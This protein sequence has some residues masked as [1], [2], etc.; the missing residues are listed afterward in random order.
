MISSR[1]YDL[2]WLRVIAFL[3][4]I[5]FHS[6][7]FF[8]PGGIPMI[9]NA[10]TSTGLEVFVHISSQF[11]LGLL[12][13]I[14]GVGV[15]FARRR[16][17][18]WEFVC[19]RSRRLLIPLLV[20]I[21]FIVP[22]MIYVEKLFLGEYVGSFVSFYP[23]FFTQGVYPNGNLS[24]HHFWFIAYLFIYCLMAVWIFDWMENRGK[25]AVDRWVKR[26]GG[27]GIYK[28]IALLLAIEIPL[29]ALFP[30]FRDLIHDWASFSHWFLLFIA[31][32][33]V[34]NNESILENATRLRFISLSGAVVSIVLYYL[35]FGEKDLIVNYGDK[36]LV[37]K[38]LAYCVI[39]ITMAW[40]CILTCLGFAGRHLRFN[41]PALAFLSEAVYPLFILHLTIIT[42]LGY[43]VVEQPWALSVKYMAITTG[44]IVLTLAC[45]RWCIRPFNSMRLLFGVKPKGVVKRV[46]VSNTYSA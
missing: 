12:F 19:E 40:C 3:I 44:T 25:A 5:Y 28:F 35:V 29:R 2:D 36:L 6:A 34:A 13:F 10:E 32:F 38:Y 7:I 24:W 15:A 37:P 30:G 27:Y 42:I 16:K 18:P 20:G 9:Q 11:R 4:L 41:S 43:W 23:Q 14:S 8:I 17:T 26:C 1:R 39:R 21:L 33:V 45:Y 22:P 31:G 46:M